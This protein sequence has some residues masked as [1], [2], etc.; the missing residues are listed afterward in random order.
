MIEHR[1]HRVLRRHLVWF[2]FILRAACSHARWVP[3]GAQ[4]E[5][6]RE[7][8]MDRWYRRWRP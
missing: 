5:Q 1:Q 8:G 6:R 3:S 7:A 4:R 2:D